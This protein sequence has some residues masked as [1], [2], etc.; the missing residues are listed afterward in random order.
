MDNNFTWYIMYNATN[1]EDLRS[2]KKPSNILTFIINL[3]FSWPVFSNIWV[4]YMSLS[5][6]LYYSVNYWAHSILSW[7]SLILNQIYTDVT[8]YSCH[9]SP[10]I[11]VILYPILDLY[12]YSY[13]YSTDTKWNKSTDSYVPHLL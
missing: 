3:Y 12:K 10:H 8:I 7:I 1:N 2:K 11:S 9:I 13:K 4:F 5:L 6:T